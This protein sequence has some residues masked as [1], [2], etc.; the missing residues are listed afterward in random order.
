M[1]KNC[2]KQFIKKITP[3]SYLLGS[4][5]RFDY[6]LDGPTRKRTTLMVL[7]IALFL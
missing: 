2:V 7:V 6:P 1:W 4:N 3:F 5:L